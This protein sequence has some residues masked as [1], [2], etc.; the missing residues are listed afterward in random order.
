MVTV[1]YIG[2]KTYIRETKLFDFSRNKNREELE[3]TLFNGSNLQWH[4]FAMAR[5][6]A[7]AM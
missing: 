6:C 7:M 5:Y 4:R 3:V 1:G 2:L